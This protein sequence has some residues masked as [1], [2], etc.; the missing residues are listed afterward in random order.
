M[1]RRIDFLL[2]DSYAI[3]CDAGASAME[4]EEL[5]KRGINGIVVADV[6]LFADRT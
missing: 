6:R 5:L 3:R 2:R 1:F 4:A